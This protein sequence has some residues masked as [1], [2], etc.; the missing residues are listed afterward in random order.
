MLVAVHLIALVVAASAGRTGLF[1]RQQFQ[2]T[3]TFNIFGPSGS[4]PTVCGP[5][6]GMSALNFPF[7]PLAIAIEYID[8]LIL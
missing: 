8:Q 7:S 6:S 2:G 5:I 1:P 3:A 4:G